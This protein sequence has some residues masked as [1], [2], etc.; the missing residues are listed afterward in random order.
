MFCYSNPNRLRQTRFSLGPVSCPPHFHRG[1]G[2]SCVSL[3]S[4]SP[5]LAH[6]QRSQVISPEGLGATVDVFSGCKIKRSGSPATRK[7]SFQ[8]QECL[9][10]GAG[11][12]AP[13]VARSAL[14][15]CSLGSCSTKS[16][17]RSKLGCREA[18]PCVRGTG[19]IPG[20]PAQERLSFVWAE[21]ACVGAQDSPL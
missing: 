6:F 9:K 15:V 8:I 18:S 5:P 1:S 21:V 2:C 10:P 4:P 14:P 16:S 12:I 17:P 19:I 13:W 7:N 20:Q 11:Q 3:S